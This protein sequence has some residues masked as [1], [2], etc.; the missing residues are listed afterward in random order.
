MRYWF[1]DDPYDGLGDSDAEW[2]RPGLP[3]SGGGSVLAD[4]TPQWLGGGFE[5]NSWYYDTEP[6]GW[7]YSGYKDIKHIECSPTGRYA[8]VYY[9]VSSYWSQY[10]PY[11]RLLYSIQPASID[12]SYLGWKSA[13]L[14]IQQTRDF[15]GPIAA[16]TYLHTLIPISGTPIPRRTAGAPVEVIEV[17]IDGVLQTKATTPHLFDPATGL[18]AGGDYSIV[19]G[20]T[21]G[22]SIRI[23]TA[24]PGGSTLTV[25]YWA[26]GDAA[27]YWPGNMDFQTTLAGTGPWY[28]TDYLAGA[29]GW[30]TYK[31]NTDHFMDTPPKGEVD[32]Y[33]YW[34]PGTQPR[35]GYYETDLF[36]VTYLTAA[37]GHEGSSKDYF[38]ASAW[39]GVYWLPAADLVLPVG[40]LDI[41]D[42]AVLSNFE[43]YGVT[44]GSPYPNPPP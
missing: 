16:G 40:I 31:A 23:F 9:D 27:G 28:M 14:S 20:S 29:G 8:D 5:F 26:R 43:N 42:V 18:G 24:V 2:I 39:R 6:A 4:F 11:G 15:A 21:N 19:G 17:R 13:P 35:D 36:D 38:S 37:I 30:A 44:F 10:W 33:W 3:A 7:L 25:M 1:R 34:I 32:W 41:Y 12:Q 22:P